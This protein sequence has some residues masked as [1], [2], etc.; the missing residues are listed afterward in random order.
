MFINKRSIIDTKESEDFSKH[1]FSKFISILPN[2]MDNLKV[3]WITYR[4][5]NKLIAI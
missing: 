5:D 3:C 4:F 1:L 2:L